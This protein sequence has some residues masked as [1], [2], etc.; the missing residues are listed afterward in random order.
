MEVGRPMDVMTLLIWVA[1][2]GLF[3][4][5]IR[6]YLTHRA[7]VELAVVLVFSSTAALFA[8]SAIDQLVPDLSPYLGTVGNLMLVAQPVLMIRLVGLIVPLRG[9][10]VPA[11]LA[12]LL[13]SV[14]AFYGTGRSVPAVLFLV[15]YFALTEFL[16]AAELVLEGRRRRGLPRIRLETAGVASMLFGLSIFVAGLGAA[17][18]GSATTTDS[19][20]M[21][22]SRLLALVAGLGYLAAFAPPRWMREIGQRALAFDLVRSI[23]SSPTGTEPR[24]LWEALATVVGDILGTSMVS[25]SVTDPAEADGVDGPA[26]LVDRAHADAG[27]GSRSTTLEVP[28]LSEGAHVATLS[29]ELSGRPLFLEDDVALIELLG[30]MTARAVERERA[31][32]AVI[33][34]T[35]ALDEAE[36]VRVSEARFRAL[37]EAEPNAI[38]SIDAGGV[39]RWCTRSATEMFRVAHGELDGRRL[40]DL[41]VPEGRSRQPA[42]QGR[43]VVRYETTGTRG[44]GTTFPAEVAVNDFEFEQSQWQLAVVS[45]ITWRRETEM[46]RDR[47]IGVLSHELRTPI[48]SIYGGAQVLRRHDNRLTDAQRDELLS[49]VAAESE[50][51]QQIIENLLVL[52]RVEQGAAVADVG[53]VMLHRILPD[54]VARERATW[55][56]LSITMD[57]PSSLPLVSGDEASISVVLRNLISNAGKYAGAAARVSITAIDEGTGRVAVRVRDDGP[58]FNPDQADLLFT[59]YFRGDSATPAPGSGI[60]LFVC[61]QLVSGMGGHMWA[62]TA[63]GGGAEFGFSL[64]LY[65]E[66]APDAQVT[67]RPADR[68]AILDHPGRT[69]GATMPAPSAPVPPPPSGPAPSSAGR[70]RAALRLRRTD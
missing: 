34:A 10:V 31:V 21:I 57:I 52:A 63:P 3:G 56:T 16:A 7:S 67:A 46:M 50:R 60:G 59:V 19:A 5:S 68:P 25:V 12:G 55:S 11:A 18:R 2:Y 69:D 44:D 24:R 37:L 64:A 17:A 13:V 47:F 42:E 22:A 33:A 36:A 54:V 35:R 39:I 28:I 4:V 61:R 15:G 70:L 14:V 43:D 30:S 1:F 45:D 20:V 41:V 53:P 9:W 58:G 51:L 38:L 27:P 48:T 49:D 62:S 8:V 23:T 29:A 40:D 66:V 26:V 6:R 65:A 32:A